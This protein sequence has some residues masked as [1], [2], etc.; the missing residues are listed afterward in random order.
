M[1]GGFTRA[2]TSTRCTVKAEAIARALG[3]HRIGGTWMAGCPAHQDNTPSL[4]IRDAD[5]GKVL[6]RCHAGCDQERV[7]AA[8]GERGLW[9]NDPSRP[10]SNKVRAPFEHKPEPDDTRRI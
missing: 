9:A 5:G 2:P 1:A 3:G 4:S 7:I 6:V 8:L 10:P